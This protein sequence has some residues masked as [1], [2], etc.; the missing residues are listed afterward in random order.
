MV[1][2]GDI[3]Q[4]LKNGHDEPF[5]HTRTAGLIHPAAV[6]WDESSTDDTFPR[7]GDDHDIIVYLNT[8]HASERCLHTVSTLLQDYRYAHTHDLMTDHVS[9]SIRRS[10][11][12]HT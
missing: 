1:H 5:N 8:R 6:F 11:T 4:Y 3:Y 9:M 2:E 12:I 7:N 10:Q